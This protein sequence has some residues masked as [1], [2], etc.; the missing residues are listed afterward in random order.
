MQDDFADLDEWLA[1]MPGAFAEGPAVETWTER[2]VLIDAGERVESVGD[3]VARCGERL[4][5]EIWRVASWTD[6]QRA[7]RWAFS[8]IPSRFLVVE[9]R[10]RQDACFY[11]QFLSKP[12][13]GTVL[14]EVASD[15]W[16][17]GLAACVGPVEKARIL[18]YGFGK[19]GR[20]PC[21]FRQE[22]AI[23]SL[24][25]ARRVAAE[26]LALFVEVAGWRGDVALT[27]FSCAER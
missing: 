17:P 18:A 6:A 8:D 14:W 9:A 7:R 26:A 21:N 15:E 1:T 2:G 4:A 20:S 25:D 27:T 24:D 5:G 19:S 16:V 23:A 12:V 11:V 13:H 10:V 3:L 22:V